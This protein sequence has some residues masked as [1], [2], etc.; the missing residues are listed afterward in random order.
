[1]QEYVQL[2]SEGFLGKICTVLTNSSVL[3]V[4]D[5]VQHS[6]YFTGEVQRIDRY[7]IWVKHI[8]SGTMGFFAFP[9]VGIVE[10]QVIAQ[11]DPRHEKLKEEVQK[12]K[13][14]K[15]AFQKPG[16]FMSVEDLVATVK[17]KVN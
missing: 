3:P 17:K 16:T 1:M 14:G 5:A 4:K 10:E 6:Q 9:I 7:G 8:T 2:L 12:Q 13:A 15:P 11:D